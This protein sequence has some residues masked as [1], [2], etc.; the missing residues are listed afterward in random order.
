M[1]QS[2]VFL[3]AGASQPFGI[4]T[5]QQ[6]VSEFEEEIKKSNKPSVRLYSKIKTI[7]QK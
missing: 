1:A 4:P 6:L 7:Q 5:M 3:G 2:L